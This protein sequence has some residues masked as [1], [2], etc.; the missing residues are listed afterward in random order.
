MNKIISIIGATAVLALSAVSC[1]KQEQNVPDEGRIV[2]LDVFA[3][4][5]SGTKTWMGAAGE[6]VIPVYWSDGDKVS[7]NGVTSSPVSIPEATQLSKATFQARNVEAPFNVLYP[8]EDV[9]EFNNVESIFKIDIPTT[10]AYTPASFACG[11]AILYGSSE[12]ETAPVQLKNLCGA[13]KVTLKDEAAVIKSLVL[14]SLGD[15]PITGLFNINVKTG[16]LQSVEGGKTVT[17]VLPEGGVALSAAGTPFIITIPQ[18]S[19][20]EGFSLRFEDSAKHILK[21]Y[22]LRPSAGAEA[23]VEVKGGQIVTF[24][25]AAYDPDAREI[26]CA[27]DWEEFAAA[28][29]AG[30]WESDWLGKDGSVKIGAD[31]TATK[32]TKVSEFGATLNGNGHTITVTA[33]TNPIF[34]TITGT[35]KNLTIA[36]KITPADPGTE[37]AV[38]FASILQN[39]T[40]EGCTNKADIT[41]KTAKKTVC[42]GLVRSF[43]G[44]LVKNCVNEG[45]LTMSVDVNSADQ[46]FCGGGIVATVPELTGLAT[47]SGCINKGT[48]TFTTTKSASSTHRPVHSG[49]G[50]IIGTAVAGDAVNYLLIE[51]CENL[52][53]VI[54]NYSAAP[55]S[56]SGLMSGVGG[57]IGIASRLNTTGSTMWWWAKNKPAASEITSEDC[58][59][60]ELKNCINRADISSDL[61]ST[62][63]SDDPYKNG[64]GGVAGVLNGTDANHILVDGC[65]NYGKVIGI[66]N[67]YS[68]SALCGVIGGLCGIVT[69]VDFNNCT[70]KSEQ[71]GTAKRQNYSTV[72]ALGYVTAT[73][74]MTN[75]SIYAKLSHVRTERFSEGNYGLGFC[76]STKAPGDGGL[77]YTFVKIDGSEISGCRFG[78]TATYN[79]AVVTYSATTPKLDKTDTFTASSYTDWIAAPSILA[80]VNGQNFASKVTYSNNSYWDGNE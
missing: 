60:A 35:V 43:K 10:Q 63:S 79:S 47:I 52:G 3:A 68:R 23:G 73:F 25:A 38:S 42:G 67:K 22:W 33:G 12:S 48:L 7:I 17:I 54:A 21:N 18:G 29:N 32:L 36:G 50:G 14:T 51:N 72:A 74:K 41:S 19:Y 49:F 16:E 76:L 70:V 55:T 6:G 69:Y 34:G 57:I 78:G 45:N 53:N 9:V 62:C 77:Y 24:A 37:G 8:A 64:V 61:V 27:E 28:C 20:P 59:Y 11:S 44:G 13:I 65:K 30:S 75:C 39:G 46:P 1:S 66:E 58:V 31:F 26:T 71:V 4:D 2:S 40:L 80:D 15:A 56:A 5:N